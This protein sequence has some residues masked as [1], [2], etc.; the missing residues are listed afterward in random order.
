VVNPKY[1]TIIL[2]IQKIFVIFEF[3]P[4][5][6]RAWVHAPSGLAQSLLLTKLVLFSWTVPLRFTILYPLTL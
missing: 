3:S 4:A 2:T 5:L 1:L 6:L